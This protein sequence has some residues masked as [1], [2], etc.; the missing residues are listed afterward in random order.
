M[1][2][3]YSPSLKLAHL[4]NGEDVGT[5]GDLTNTNICTLLEQAITGW[6]FIDMVDANYTLTN[7]DGAVNEARNVVLAVRGTNTAT[8]DVIV[9]LINKLYIVYNGTNGSINV[10][11]ATGAGVTLVI[12]ETLLVFVDGVDVHIGLNHAIVEA[13]TG[14]HVTQIGNRYIISVP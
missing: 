9:P 10:R 6:V 5:W 14:C 11:G 12:G 8:R 13:G 4:G 3:T 2:T 1:P 7:S